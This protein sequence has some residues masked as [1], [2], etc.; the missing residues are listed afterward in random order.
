MSNAN[1]IPEARSGTVQ[2]NVE[3]FQ[4]L[5]NRVQ[6]RW[7]SSTYSMEIQNRTLSDSRRTKN[8]RGQLVRQKSGEQK[9]I[10]KGRRKNGSSWESV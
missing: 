6:Q 2:Q 8:Y 9:R 7:K 4:N 5:G 3:P 1:N 10:K